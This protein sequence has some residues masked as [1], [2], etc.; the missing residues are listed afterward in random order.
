MVGWEVVFSPDRKFAVD[1]AGFAVN[2]KLVLNSNATFGSFCKKKAA[3]ET[4]FLE[5]F[6]I[7]LRDLQPFGFESEHKE[8]L[9]WHTRTS[10]SAVW[11]NNHGFIV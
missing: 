4:C 1:M 5:Q 8:V 2:L 9:V 7:S 11:G 6:G 3:P 10:N